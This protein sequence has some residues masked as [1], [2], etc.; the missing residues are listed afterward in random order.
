M[1]YCLAVGWDQRWT[2]LQ[3]RRV[4]GG[5]LPSIPAL[6]NRVSEA[7]GMSREGENTPLP[8][9]SGL[10]KG[11]F[12]KE[13]IHYYPSH[14]STTVDLVHFV[15]SAS[16]KSNKRLQDFPRTVHQWHQ[17][18]RSQRKLIMNKET[19]NSFKNATMTHQPVG[20]VCT[21]LWGKNLEMLLTA[22]STTLL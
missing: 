10:K 12:L 16:L 18:K 1:I 13:Y 2:Q 11:L 8:S 3:M 15:D 20:S 19:H 4:Q 6:E 22:G 9:S 14:P 17:G 5:I 7:A 21:G